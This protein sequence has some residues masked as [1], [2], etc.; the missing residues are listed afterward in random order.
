MI[1]TNINITIREE[2]YSTKLAL[3]L[4]N[5]MK[6]STQY[7]IGNEVGLSP[8]NNTLEDGDTDVI[9]LN[10]TDTLLYRN[11]RKTT[12]ER[13]GMTL[14]YMLDNKEFK[15]YTDI[16][17]HKD[18]GNEIIMAPIEIKSHMDNVKKKD[19]L[20]GQIALQTVLCLDNADDNMRVDNVYFCFVSSEINLKIQ[21]KGNMRFLKA[22]SKCESEDEKLDTLESYLQKK[23]LFYVNDLLNDFFSDLNISFNYFVGL[24][25]DNQP[26]YT[27]R[28]LKKI[29]F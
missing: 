26:L 13:N 7:S 24:V 16:L 20:A 23:S 17:I 14:E 29:E 4:Q 8:T 5:V 12:I 28:D 6:N 3:G 27:F 25:D 18:T 15:V 1:T 22:L 21:E 9:L 19:S 10:N 2:I 11:G